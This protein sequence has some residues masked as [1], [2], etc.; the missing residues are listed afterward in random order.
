MA[1]MSLLVLPLVSSPLVLLSFA[2]E[3]GKPDI[4][5]INKTGTFN[6]HSFVHSLTSFQSLLFPPSLH[7]SILIAFYVGESAMPS[8]GLFGTSVATM[9]MLSSAVYVLAMD[10]FGPIAGEKEHS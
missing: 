7:R 10:T 4:E 9:G 5:E 2:L 1:P 6:F 3:S 8:G